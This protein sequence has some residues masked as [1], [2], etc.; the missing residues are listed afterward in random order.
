MRFSGGQ[1][2]K[3]GKFNGILKAFFMNI[4]NIELSSPLIV[5]PMAGVT[6]RP[7]RT[8]CREFGAGLAVSEMVSANTVLAKTRKTLLRLDHR[9]EAAPIAVQIAGSDPEEM[10]KAAQR[11]LAFGAQIIDINMGCPAKKVCQVSAGSALLQNESLVG[12]ILDAVVAAVPVPVTLKTRTGYSREQKNIVRIAKMAENAGIAALAIHGRTRA[13]FYTGEAEFDSIAEVRSHI[14][15]PLIANGDIT[16]PER[17]LWVLQKTGA[18]AVMIGRGAQGK[19][20]IFQEILHFLQHGE[21]LPS[22]SPAEIWAIMQRHLLAMYDFYGEVAGVRIARKHIAWYVQ[23]FF[24]AAKF[25]QYAYSLQ[26]SAEQ[27][28]ACAEFFAQAR[29]TQNAA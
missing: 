13:D 18:D 6:D 10:A 17:A 14:S 7:F 22:R 9:G 27:M 3:L 2:R 20:W 26:S 24:D 5:A 19:P 23:G 1:N 21:K 29:Y 4:G 28:Q 8:L 16:T 11:N 25:R 12:K 15:I